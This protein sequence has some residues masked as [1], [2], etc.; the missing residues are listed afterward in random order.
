MIMNEIGPQEDVSG[1]AARG[2]RAV[3]AV[4]LALCVLAGAAQTVRG[5]E[6]EEDTDPRHIT[7]A[8]FREDQVGEQEPGDWKPLTFDSDGGIKPSRYRVVK[9]DGEA[10]IRAKTDEGASALVREIEVDPEEYPYIAWRWRV[11]QPFP[12][13]DGTTKQGDDYPARL[14]VAFKYDSSRAGW[15]TRMK[16][17][18][19]KGEGDYS[20]YPPLWALNY[21]WAN[22]LKENTWIVNPWQERSKMIAVRSGSE[23]IGEW[24]W[25]VRN[26]LKD[27]RAIVGE[28]PTNVKFIAVMIDGDNTKSKGTAYFGPIQL[29]SELPD[30][31]EGKVPDPPRRH[32]EDRSDAGDPAREEAVTVQLHEPARRADLLTRAGQCSRSVNAG[33][34]GSGRQSHGVWTCSSTITRF[35]SGGS[36]HRERRDR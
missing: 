32:G 4:L 7:L 18:M 31:F 14:Y 34:T 16:F 2:L 35:R 15:W 8:R 33:K 13:G 29:W 20:G 36:L 21:V 6:A 12:R 9:K 17:R 28:E 25:E 22:T 10:V 3:P 1:P 5:Q 19:A 24:H 23:G 27:F 11:E 30:R 26:Y